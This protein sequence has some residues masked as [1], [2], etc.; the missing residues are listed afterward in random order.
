MKQKNQLFILDRRSAMKTYSALLASLYFG[1]NSAF[2][3]D[4]VLN[5][6]R[7]GLVIG[8]SKYP[9]SPLTNPANDAVAISKVLNLLGFNTSLLMDAS[10]KNLSSTI[11][12]YTDQ[13]SKQKAVGFFY[14]AGHGVQLGWRNYLVPVDA[15]IDRVDDIPKKTYE[16]NLMLA[17]LTKA[18]NPMNIII[19]DACRDNPFGKKLPIEQ[20]GLSQFD[21]PPNSLLCY[22]TAPGNVASDGSGTNGLFTENLL[23]EMCNP[24]AKIEDVMKRVRLNVRLTSKGAQIPWESTSLED[25]FF[26]NSQGVDPQFIDAQVKQALVALKG[27]INQASKASAPSAILS[28]VEAKPPVIEAQPIVSAPSKAVIDVT[29]KASEE[30]KERLFKEELALWEKAVAESSLKLIEDYLQRYPNGSFSQLAQVRLDQLLAKK[31]EKKVQIIGSIDNPFSKGSASIVG[32]YSIGDNYSFELKD[33]LTGVVKNSYND[34]VTEINDEK[35]IF[36]NGERIID[37]LGNELK[38]KSSRF[39]TPA[40]FYPVEYGVGNKWTTRYGWVLGN[41]IAS[42]IEMDFVV[43]ARNEFKSSLGTFNAFEIAGTGYALK[44]SKF[45]IKYLIDPNKCAQPLVFEMISTGRGGRRGAGAFLDKVELVS[46]SQ[47]KTST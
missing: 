2:A 16:L 30:E 36:N 17:A 12:K 29:K 42:E 10:L 41:G 19:L 4:K 6:P 39:L 47:K 35:I 24:T 37:A 46:F 9:D 38:S 18:Q 22:A 7:S 23:R 14:Y 32:A 45:D 8:N 40:Q 44:G 3:S 11:Q 15:E 1:R 33:L 5:G 27:S 25:D 21:A 13:L 26:F 28:A 20:K 34:V 43:K 31:G